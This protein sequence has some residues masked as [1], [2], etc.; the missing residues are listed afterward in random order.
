MTNVDAG[1]RA[2]E[3]AA[4]FL[5]RKGCR[6]LQRNWRTRYCEIDIVASRD[7]TV[8]LCEVKYRLRATQGT[9]LEYITPKK[10]ARMRFAAELWVQAN[11]WQGAYELCAIEVSGSQF[12]ITGVVRDL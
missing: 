7:D 2:E 4:L 6:I 8:Y 10:L 1:R 11:G 3:A 5:E 12:Q 9:G